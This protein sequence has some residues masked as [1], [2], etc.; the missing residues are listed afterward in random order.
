MYNKI[1]VLIPC[2]VKSR[3]YK[4]RLLLSFFLAQHGFKVIFGRK[5]EVEYFARCFSN[6]IYIGLHST[7]TYFNF[8]KK[9]KLNNN[10]LILFDEEGL[11][12][13]SKN[14]YL[15]TKFSK[16]IAN[17]C[18]I[19]FCWGEKSHKFLSKNRSLYKDKLKIAGNLRFDIIKKKFNFLIKKN[20]DLIK[21]K[22]K[23]YILISCSFGNVNHLDKRYEKISF[24]RKN[25]YLIDKQSLKNYKYYCD[26]NKT[27]FNKN[28]KLIEFLALE[29]QN[30]NFVVRPHPSEKIESYY[31]LKKKY[32]NVYISKE[33]SI[34]E[35]LKWSKLNIH[36]YCTT[37]L[38]ASAMGI[39]NLAFRSTFN[40]KYLVNIPYLMSHKIHNL[41]DVKKLV[42]MMLKNKDKNKKKNKEIEKHIYNFYSKNSYSKIIDEIKNLLKKNNKNEAKFKSKVDLNKKRFLN[43]KFL[44]KDFGSYTDYK[45]PDITFPQ[46]KKDLLGFRKISRSKKEIK[47][48]KFQ[49]NVFEISS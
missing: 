3:D 35:W 21:K 10:K 17:I 34:S 42:T 24:L 32:S 16:K 11:V 37:S 47:I 33:F 2:E 40:K 15:K 18:D 19:F 9:I 6:S 31:D 22:Y 4:P 14:T 7:N 43:I 5:A 30:I 41:D 25:K 13:L 48:S 26:Y 29:Y 12:T 20:S 44:F 8:Y 39:E 27:K 46:L 45:T 28:L 36:Y 38:E 23:S 1:I 49:K